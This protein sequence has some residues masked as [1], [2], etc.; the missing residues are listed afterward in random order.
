LEEEAMALRRDPAS[1]TQTIALPVFFANRIDYYAHARGDADATEVGKLLSES[2][3]LTA[4]R[5][6]VVLGDLRYELLSELTVL[7]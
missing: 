2:N 6:S 7:E 4:E 5:V 3:R 1:C